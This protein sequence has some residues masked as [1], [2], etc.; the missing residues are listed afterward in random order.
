MYTYIHT[1]HTPHT[2]IRTQTHTY[3]HTRYPTSSGTGVPY[4]TSGTSGYG[5]SGTSGHR[6]DYGRA[7]DPEMY[8]G[9]EQFPGHSG[10][11]TQ[12]HHHTGKENYP[13]GTQFSGTS[14]TGPG[15]PGGVKEVKSTTTVLHT[16][17]VE[18]GRSTTQAADVYERERLP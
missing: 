9:R 18:G 4:G 13:G 15:Y 1:S 14:G 11:G 17:V 2:Y 3:V 8:A 12:Q 16:D 10:T 7:I 5:T 6:T